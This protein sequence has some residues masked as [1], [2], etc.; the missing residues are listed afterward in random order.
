LTHERKNVLR[1]NMSRPLKALK[2]DRKIQ[3]QIGKI[4]DSINTDLGNALQN[5]DVTHWNYTTIHKHWTFANLTTKTKIGQS[6]H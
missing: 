3:E 5:S 2:L 4:Q 1:Y 6:C